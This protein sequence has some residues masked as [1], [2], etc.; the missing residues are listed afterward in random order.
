MKLVRGELDAKARR[1]L[2]A[3]LLAGCSRCSAALL[4]AGA[5]RLRA[6]GPESASRALS[7]R[8][9]SRWEQERSG[10]AEYDGVIARALAT[11]HRQADALLADRAV[12][13]ERLEVLLD[14][15]RRQQLLLRNSR[16]YRSANL[17]RELL[18]RSFAERFRDAELM[19]RLAELGVQVAEALSDDDLRPALR[20]DLCAEAWGYLANARRVSSDLAGA[21][22]ALD[23]AFGHLDQGLGDPAL[24]ARLLTFAAS[25]RGDQRRLRECTRA[26][27][28]ACSIYRALGEKHLLGRTLILH[29]GY[30]G[31]SEGFEPF[32]GR[33]LLEEGLALIDSG[34]EPSL[35]VL[36]MHNLVSFT[37]LAGRP[38]EAWEL[39]RECRGLYRRHLGALACIKLLWLEG[40]IAA[41]LG[42]L[43][44]AAEALT[45]ARVQL[46]IRGL[47]YDVALVSLE[48][49][50]VELRRERDLA[51]RL[52]VEEAHGILRAEGVDREAL[53]AVI[54]LR[55][56]MRGQRRPIEQLR[57][58]MV[59]LR[60][61]EI[62][63]KAKFRR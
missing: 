54:V 62:D 33:A 39:L 43:D 13:G 5:R 18:R 48:L 59:Y 7:G 3:H 51:A 16:R 58:L 41:G 49:A 10:S 60:R 15:P 38:R 31:T 55:R 40:S 37:S 63:S 57:Q 12:A 34:R 9:R 26:L 52:L 27:T 23:R 50:L 6:V 21:D 47:H 30:R 17:C 61:Q 28:Q 46:Q 14:Q 56:A 22:E 44:R 1:P 53:A 19:L 45:R 24:R 20:F 29:G 25:L 36:A 42:R 2:F 35:V 4:A 8:P 32:G 11:A